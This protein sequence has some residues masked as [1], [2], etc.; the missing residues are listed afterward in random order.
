MLTRPKRRSAASRRYFLSHPVISEAAATTQNMDQ[1]KNKN[2]S[3]HRTQLHHC[4]DCASFLRRKL[5][6]KSELQQ[7]GSLLPT[8]PMCPGRSQRAQLAKSL[9]DWLPPLALAGRRDARG[10]K[11]RPLC[12]PSTPAASSGEAPAEQNEIR[13]PRTPLPSPELGKWRLGASRISGH[14][15]AR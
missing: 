5:R 9:R 15:R 14:N 1:K 3:T 7:P 2:D 11:G 6:K 4:L 8:P 13:P 12:M 10:G